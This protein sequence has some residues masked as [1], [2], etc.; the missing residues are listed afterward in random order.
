M[1]YL[2]VNGGVD[3]GQPAAQ[4]VELLSKHL[5]ALLQ[6]LQ[7]VGSLHGSFENIIISAANWENPS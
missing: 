2:G 6:L 3:P 7:N 5:L 1:L 4:V